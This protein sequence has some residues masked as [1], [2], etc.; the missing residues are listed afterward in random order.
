MHHDNE[1]EPGAR[2]ESL[3]LVTFDAAGRLLRYVP[4]SYPPRYEY[5]AAFERLWLEGQE[6]I[7]GPLWGMRR[8]A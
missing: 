6:R 3:P 5:D 4:E 1:T 8:A 7:Y 2:R